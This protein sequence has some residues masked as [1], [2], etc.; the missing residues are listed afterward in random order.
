MA[1]W[2][3]SLS[4]PLVSFVDQC[5]RVFQQSP[6]HFIDRAASLIQKSSPVSG[7]GNLPGEST[8]SSLGF[9]LCAI[10]IASGL[11][12]E[13]GL[14]GL[15]YVIGVVARMLYWGQGCHISIHYVLCM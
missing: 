8:H 14:L 6:F 7:S 9:V 4:L 1:I 11:G 2:I 13:D 5:A 12:S 10:E 3:S 15:E